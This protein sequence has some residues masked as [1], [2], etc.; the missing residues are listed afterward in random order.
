MQPL[1]DKVLVK[2]EIP[3]DTTKSGIVLA[4][5][6]KDLITRGQVIAIGVGVKEVVVVDHILF[7]PY[8]WER[9]DDGE[10]IILM[11]ELDI[12]AIIK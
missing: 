12:W 10:E 3:G 6:K 8:D 4:A 9:V 5:S 11:S 7:S 1:G 2:A